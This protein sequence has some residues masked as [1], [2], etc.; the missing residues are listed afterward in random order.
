MQSDLDIAN[1][2]L[3]NHLH[4][5]DL[6]LRSGVLHQSN[7]IVL[8]QPGPGSHK[9]DLVLFIRDIFTRLQIGGVEFKKKALESL[10]QLL[11]DDDKS[12]AVVAKEGNVGYLISL[13]DFHHQ[14]SIREQAVLALSIIVSANDESRKIVF[15]EGGLGP[16]LRILETGSM[17]LKE[18]AAIGVEA[19]TTDPENA[20]A[21]SAYGGVS[22]LIEAFRSGTA[23]TQSHAVG[24]IRNI[25]AV[26]DIKAA[27]AEEGAVPVLVQ[28][29]TSSSN[30]AQENAA[31]CIATLAASVHFL[32]QIPRPEYC[33]RPLRS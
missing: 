2:S 18:K 22:V 26:E 27:L 7:A 31:D 24:A 4:D 13:L 19:I 25:A 11:K 30:L 28:S 5:L 14:S 17:P 20:W 9:Q 10:L 16:L 8:S 12:A 21:I 6:L 1:T 32:Y 3:S 29:L 23:L 33:H 15:E